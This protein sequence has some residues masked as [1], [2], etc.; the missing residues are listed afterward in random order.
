MSRTAEVVNAVGAK[1]TIESSTETLI[2]CCKALLR[3]LL[4]E[5]HLISNT[6]RSSSQLVDVELDIVVVEATHVVL[7]SESMATGRGQLVLSVSRGFGC[8]TRPGTPLTSRS[9][10][11]Y[12]LYI[13]ST[14]YGKPPNAVELV[15][16]P[17]ARCWRAA[18]SAP[19]LFWYRVT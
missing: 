8:Q 17:C 19:P 1:P 6:S 2:S 13:M 12:L 14:V 15:P 16:A 9:Q 18:G 5:P 4:E 10:I 11:E 7:T 3:S